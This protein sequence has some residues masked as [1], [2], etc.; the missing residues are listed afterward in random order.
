MVT[1]LDTVSKA[2]QERPRHPEKLRNPD[3]PVLRKPSW[4]RVKAP[5]SPVYNETRKIMRENGRIRIPE[6][7]RVARALALRF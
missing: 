7:F 5:G 1:L 4:I 3:T 2:Q 6:L